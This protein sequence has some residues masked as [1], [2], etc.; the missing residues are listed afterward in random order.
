MCRQGKRADPQSRRALV[1]I[2]AEYM[3]HQLHDITHGA[4]NTIA[5]EICNKYPKTFEDSIFN[6]KFGS[7][8]EALREQ[9]YRAINFR[10]EKVPTIKTNRLDSD[11]KDSERRKKRKKNQS[12]Q[13][14]YGCV[15]YAPRLPDNEAADSQEKNA[16][17]L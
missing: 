11:D 17:Y 3:M 5:K 1:V 2:V 9:I 15:Q 4:C 16:C 7:G 10:K 8:H 14:E 6:A 13:D 12:K